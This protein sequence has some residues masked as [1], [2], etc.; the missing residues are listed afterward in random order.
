M[1]NQNKKTT[2]SVLVVGTAVVVAASTVRSYNQDIY[3]RFP[4]V[5]RKVARKAYRKMLWKAFNGELTDA[6]TSTDEIMDVV[7]LDLVR[8]IETAS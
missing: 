7:F 2:A 5:D 3:N 8:Q 1:N 4:Q 6:Q